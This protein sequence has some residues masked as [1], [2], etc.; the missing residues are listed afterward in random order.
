[1]TFFFNGGARAPCPG[2][3]RVLVPRPRD[4]PTYDQKPQ[5]SAREV[6]DERRGALAAGALDFGVVNFANADMVGHT[7][8]LAAAVTAVE[9]VDACLGGS[10]RAV[11]SAAAPA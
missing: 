3:R 10:S 6:T 9:T 1:M 7:G 8:V 2:E 5:M 4:V 11:P